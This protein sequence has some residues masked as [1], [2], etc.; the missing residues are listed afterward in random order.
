MKPTVLIATT[1]RWFPTARLAIA[2]AKAGFDVEAVCPSRHPLGVTSAV[3][4]THTYRGLAPLSSIVAAIEA[5]SPNLIIPCDDLAILHLHQLY[6][7]A[8]R[9][10]KSGSSTCVLIERSL[11][12]PASFPVSCARAAFMALAKEEGVRAPTTEAIS[13]ISELK[14]WVT[15]MVF[16][17][18]LKSDATSG[19]EGVRVVGSLE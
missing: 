13:N 10:G 18:I 3:R 12:A 19:G 6:D 4:H 17:T 2:L 11:G 9:R 7:R 16:P 5:T 8:L 15:R 14:S 1:Y